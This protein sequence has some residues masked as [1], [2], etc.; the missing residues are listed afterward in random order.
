MRILLEKMIEDLSFEDLPVS[1]NS[2]DLEAFSKNK[3]LWNYQQEALKNAVRVLWKY[4]EDF[5][6][7]E[8][9]QNT[10]DHSK[11]KRSF[12]KWYK[13]NGL[14]EDLTVKTD[15][16]KRDV[17]TLLT[18]YYD[19]EEGRISYENFINRMCFWMATGSGKTLVIVKLIQI[20][21][22]LVERGEIPAFDIL[23][24]THRD[25]L[26]QQ[27]KRHVAEFNRGNNGIYIT[28]RELREYPEV[29]RQ[30]T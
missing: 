5:L 20:L 12:Y 8:E 13:E 21:K 15:R 17:Y 30:Q 7:Y 23:V 1:W 16:K 18:E 14:E 29:K 4:F 28:L 6:N 27:L 3:R 26:I 9:S 19:Q 11:R 22:G 25:D 10:I 24:L 2:F